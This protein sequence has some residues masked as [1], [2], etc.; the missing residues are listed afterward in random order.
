LVDAGAKILQLL[1]PR[2]RYKAMSVDF[3]FI[4]L[5]HHPPCM[6]RILAQHRPRAFGGAL[7]ASG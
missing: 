7:A 4:L 1:K 5:L 3:G 6:L 2:N